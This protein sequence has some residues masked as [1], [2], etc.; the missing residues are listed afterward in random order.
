MHETTS[1]DVIVYCRESIPSLFL[2]LQREGDT[3]RAGLWHLLTGNISAGEHPLRA[4]CRTVREQTGLEAL[5]CWAID[6]VHT[7]YDPTEDRMNFIPVFLIEVASTKLAVALEP[8]ASRWIRY[9]QALEMLRCPC[10][11][12]ELRRAQEDVV[13][14]HDRGVNFRIPLP[15]M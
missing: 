10:H 6:Y 14:S 2:L 9:D 1:V 4:A 3:R 8:N 12:E 11:R 7:C 15:A 13:T 5:D